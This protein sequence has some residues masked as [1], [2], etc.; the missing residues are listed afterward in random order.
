M[1]LD[2]AI[3]IICYERHSNKHDRLIKITGSKFLSFYFV[4]FNNVFKMKRGILFADIL[5]LANYINGIV[6]HS[7]ADIANEI[8]LLRQ[9]VDAV[10]Q[11]NSVIKQENMQIKDNMKGKQ[12]EFDQILTSKR[13]QTL[14]R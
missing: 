3:K 10:K 2:F 11:E 7:S 8:L 6:L 1:Y 4:Q 13:T 12:E 9:E 5:L 14:H